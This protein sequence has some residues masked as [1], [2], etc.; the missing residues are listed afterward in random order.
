MKVPMKNSA[1]LLFT[2]IAAAAIISAVL[3]SLPPPIDQSL[4]PQSKAL[5]IAERDPNVAAFKRAYP[6]AAHT[7]AALEPETAKQ[8]AEK[9]PVVY[10]GLPE[11]TLYEVH[12]SAG[13]VGMLLIVDIETAQVLKIFETA[14]QLL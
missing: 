1:K 11:K 5:A 3:L 6:N 13:T 9:Y 4:D 2:V 12:Y 8:K 14:H 10:G 7:V